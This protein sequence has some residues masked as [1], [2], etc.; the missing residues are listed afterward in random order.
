VADGPALAW[1]AAVIAR[2]KADATVAALV[3]ARVYDEPP[4][5][6]V[7]PYI[8]LGAVEVDIVPTDGRTAWLL[9]FGVEAHSRPVAGR[10]EATRLAETIVA[11]LEDADVDVTGFRL[12]WC[13][14]QTFTVNR[15]GDGQSYAAIIAFEAMLD[16]P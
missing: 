3:G 13:F 6:A 5:D 8:R 16:A 14:F 9:T 15:A 4:Q 11:A 10:V 12:A 1:Q 7:F 2:L